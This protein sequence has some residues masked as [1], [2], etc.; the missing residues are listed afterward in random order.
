MKNLSSLSKARYAT[1]AAIILS[2]GFF[3]PLPHWPLATAIIILTGLSIRLISKSENEIARFTDICHQLSRGNF[4]A[5]IINIEEKG[6]IGELALTIN[7][8]TDTTDSF[9][10]ESTA[11]MDY[12]SHNRY[13]R[14]ILEGGLQG[15]L[16]NGA[17]IM[18]AAMRNVAQKMGDFAAIASDFEKSFHDLA[19]DLKGTVR[20]LKS[21]SDTMQSAVS[22]VQ[23]E[24]ESA[25][26]SS[27]NSSNSVQS[28]SSAAEELSASIREISEQMSRA[29]EVANNTLRQADTAESTLQSL[30]ESAQKIG[31]IVQLIETIANQTNLLALNATI[32]AA[33][34]GEAGKGFAVVAAEVKDLASQTAQATI[35]IGEQIRHMQ[36]ITNDT[37]S[38]FS[39]IKGGIT[40][41]HSAAAAVA[42]AVEEQGAASQEIARSAETASNGTTAVAH[43]VNIINGK[44]LQ[45]DQAANDVMGATTK[46]SKDSAD[47]LA[48]MIIKMQSFMESLHKIA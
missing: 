39:D 40:S 2:L 36:D 33:R 35:S 14:R 20:S 48:D 21:S 16:L 38:A 25:V 44:I 46:L 15:S 42:A 29:S 23:Q 34:A 27:D 11:A 18:N 10:R 6:N 43:N 4:E 32:E 17:R 45:V 3:L 37:V 1:I 24:T 19:E 13:F 26:S 28:I 9:I 31:E 47:R 5:R 41:I 22:G 12:I 7:R 8:M 30:T